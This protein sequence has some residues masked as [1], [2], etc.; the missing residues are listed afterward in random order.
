MRRY[1]KSGVFLLAILIAVTVWTHNVPKSP[2]QEDIMF[3]RAMLDARDAGELRGQIP[4]TFEQEIRIIA[5]VQ[6]AVLA[7]TPGDKGLPMGSTR[8][9]K[10][11]YYARYGSCYDR[12]RA[13]EKAL[14]LFGFEVRHISA[15]STDETGSAIV[16]LLTPQVDSHAV[17]EV[18]TSRGW[19][20]VDSTGRWISL[21]DGNRPWSAD[22]L[23]RVADS[24]RSMPEW[25]SIN[26]AAMHRLFSKSFVHLP[27][28]YS[29]HGQFYPPFTPIPDVNWY[30]FIVGI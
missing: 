11:L 1:I 30:D 22:E 16:S 7:R 8:E 18:K 6:D 28:L 20:L 9:P 10:S 23:K 27:G 26:R 2:T 21:D 5:A 13:I 19:L 25:N 15:Y 24:Q 29:R 17:T 14:M 3:I 12:S 4:A